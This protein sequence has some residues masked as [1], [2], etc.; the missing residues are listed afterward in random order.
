M[1]LT[2]VVHQMFTVCNKTTLQRTSWLMPALMCGWETAEAI[3]TQ[4]GTS[5]TSQLTK[6]SGHGGN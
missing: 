3:P 1:N 4:D 2:E 6:S 5:N